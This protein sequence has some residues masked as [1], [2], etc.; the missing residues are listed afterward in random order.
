VVLS[1][2]YFWYF[3]SL[4]IFLA[5][6]NLY[7]KHLGLASWQISVVASV[8]PLARVL[9]PPIW[10]RGAD[11]TGRR[12]MLAVVAS[13][14][15]VASFLAYFRADGFAPLLLAQIVF[16]SFWSPVLP[17]VE[18]TTLEQASIERLDYGRTRM[19]GSIG[20][21]VASFGLGPLLDR[22]GIRFTL[23]A[24]LMCLVLTAVATAAA[25]RPIGTP[26]QGSGHLVA[27]LRR[28]GVLLFFAVGMLSQLSHATMYNF[29]SIR[30]A[31]L[32]FSNKAIGFLW[33]FGVICEVPVI[34]WSGIL[35]NHFKR[36][37]LIR[38][39]LVVTTIR[40]LLTATATSYPILLLAQG[41]HAVTFAVFHIAAVTYTFAIVPAPLRA[42]GQSLYGAFSFG[43]GNFVGFL[44][45]GFLYDRIGAS[46]CFTASAAVALFAAILS[47]RLREG[48]TPLLTFAPD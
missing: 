13:V 23:W 43:V 8:L 22:L 14:G 47:L 46:A 39:A 48:G 36:T 17:F 15:S 32:G 26:A 2:F 44:A 1:A 19:W 29:L 24:I 31:E 33:A 6:F 18:T 11:R 20:F 3:S 7:A 42:Q 38:F 28:P 37:S 34:R 25:P 4:A 45:N 40:W 30:L 35:L 16:A 27:F 41:M 5:F 21:I 12:H 9:W 10:T